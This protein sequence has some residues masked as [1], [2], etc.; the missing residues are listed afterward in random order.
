MLIKHFCLCFK[1]Y[2]L[3]LSLSIFHRNRTTLWLGNRR[4]RD[5]FPVSGNITFRKLPPGRVSNTSRR[6][7]TSKHRE[8]LKLRGETEYFLTNFEYLNV[9]LKLSPISQKNL[10]RIWLNLCNFFHRF[11]NIV[12]GTGAWCMNYQ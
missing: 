7:P 6:L 2:Y 4:F 12:H 3:D 1:Y 11:P 10:G 9:L 5:I 8:K